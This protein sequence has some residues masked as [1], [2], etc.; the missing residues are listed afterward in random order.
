[1]G[2]DD[3]TPLTGV[4]GG[5][6]PAEIW[7]EVMARVH[8]GLPSTPLQMIIPAP[9]LPPQTAAPSQA[10]VSAEDPA[11]QAAPAPARVG[12]PEGLLRNV[13][14]ALSANN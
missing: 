2:Y 12:K 6:L 11:P 7:H 10:Q 9:R 5:G 8:E 1:M 3:N 4:T 14:G 13:L